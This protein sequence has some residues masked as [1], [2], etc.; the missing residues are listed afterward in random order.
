M[1]VRPRPKALSDEET[2]SNSN[3]IGRGYNLL[4]GNPVC[5]TGTC[6]MEGFARPIFELNYNKKA[7][8]TCTKALIPDNVDID[9]LPSVE[10][11]AGTEI[12]STLEQLQKSTMRG[13]EVS[14][15]AKYQMAS[16][17][18]THS[19]QTN[20]MID[21]LVKSNTEVIY[22]TAK[23]SVIRLSMFEPM[24]N[25]TSQFRY[26]IDNLPCCNYTEDETR[27]YI[28][29]LV[30]NYFGYAFV[31]D[32]MLG[33]IAQ[34][35]MYI[36]KSEVKT[37]E[38]KG[39]S[40]SN[41]AKIE[42]YVSLG[43]KQQSSVNETRHNEFMRHVQKTYATTL[44]GD[45]SIQTFT[46]WSKTVK[47]NPIIIKF[48]V[49]LIF[50][51]LTA[52]R[53]PNDPNIVTKKALIE[54]ALENYIK[55]PIYCY[56]NCSANGQCKPSGYFQFGEC[57]CNDGWTGLDCYTSKPKPV[58]LS[59][60]LCGLESDV[61]CDGQYPANQCSN[62][63]G[64]TGKPAVPPANY[65][66]CGIPPF[67]VVG[68]G[69]QCAKSETNSATAGIGTICG[70]VNYGLTVLCDGRNPYS[71][72]CPIGYQRS[73][74]ASQ[75][76]FCY[77]TDPSVA[78]LPGTMCGRTLHYGMS[79]KN[80]PHYN[81][82][83]EL[84]CGG[85]YPGRSAC[86]PNYT[87]RYGRDHRHKN[88]RICGAQI[89]NIIL[90]QSFHTQYQE[91]EQFTLNSDD[92]IFV[93]VPGLMFAVSHEQP[94]VYELHFRGSYR[95]WNFWYQLFLGFIIDNRIL[96]SN[97]LLPNNDKHRQSVAADLGESIDAIDSRAGGPLING[98]TGGYAFSCAKFDTAYLSRGTHII[99]VAMRATK[100]ETTMIGGESH[101]KLTQ[102]DPD[103]N[104]NLS[105]PA[106]P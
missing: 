76:F 95:M 33:G 9:C 65:Y 91:P 64:Q 24:I 55:N 97:R 66:G 60:T 11:Q 61:A 31:T 82:V 101:A 68:N 69:N 20:Y 70:Y 86:P 99:E 44:G 56:N 3:K 105:F 87:L 12:I 92:T 41:E 30:F 81:S 50:D 59:G 25:L 53:F 28:F 2:L 71:D 35:N 42:F 16:F 1:P 14:A 84:A 17:S 63:W 43:M 75:V 78:D 34:Q 26:V 27:K 49:K 36:N 98:P 89:H 85:Y 5:Y 46:E 15:G 52:K 67:P 73:S 102:Y 100:P 103:A 72:A 37:I 106:S 38:Q 104:I 47:T 79:V 29:D 18:Y 90:T 10:V 80:K 19:T 96:N 51:L 22:T 74:T 45:S 48:G 8:G 4:T 94:T 77:K 57:Q 6:Q 39:I 23:V 62:G 54:S 83:T 21:Q 58:A 13:I 88:P 32:L 7:Q 40:T 93:K